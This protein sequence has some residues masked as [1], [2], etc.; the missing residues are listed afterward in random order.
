M[1]RL[2]ATQLYND[3]FAD[4]DDEGRVRMDNYELSDEVQKQVFEIW[5]KVTTENL[6][7]LTDFEGYKKAFL[8]LFGFG[9]D[10]VDYNKDSDINVS[11]D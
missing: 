8:G 6:G 10:G 11:I 2:F 1:Q 4:F 5:P 9:V 3:S 7:E